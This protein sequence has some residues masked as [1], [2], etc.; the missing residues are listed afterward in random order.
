METNVHVYHST[1]KRT[2][3]FLGKVKPERWSYLLRS[4]DD[5]TRFAVTRSIGEGVFY[6]TTTWRTNSTIIGSFIGVMIRVKI[7][8]EDIVRLC[9]EIFN[10]IWRKGIEKAFHNIDDKFKIPLPKKYVGLPL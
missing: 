7:G 5:M 4:A 9:Y 3:A 2:M 8:K 10:P 6:Y 1:K